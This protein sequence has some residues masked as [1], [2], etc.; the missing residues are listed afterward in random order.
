MNTPDTLPMPRVEPQALDAAAL[1][2]RAMLARLFGPPERRSFAVRLWNGVVEAAAESRFTLVLRQPAALRRMLFPPSELR[3][4]EAFI[5]GDVDVDGDLEEAAVLSDRLTERMRSP[6]RAARVAAGL[7]RLP[8]AHRARSGGDRRYRPRLRTALHTRRGDRAAVRFHY[9]LGN[10]FYRL[11]LDPRMVYSCAYFATGTEDIA[12]AQLAKLDH[13]C[14]K[15]RLKPGERLLDIGCGWGGLVVHAARCYGV[16]ALGITLSEAQAE[17]ARR[18]AAEAGMAD[19][20]RIEVRDYRE[21][22]DA[23]AFDKLVSVGMIEHVGRARLA[24]YF[25]QAFRLLKPGGCFLNHGIVELRPRVPRGPAGWPARLVWRPGRFIGQYI[26]PGGELLGPA[27]TI[28]AGEAAGFE[29]RD[30]ESLREHYAL[31]LRAWRR[32]LEERR[33]EAC[34]MVG[35]PTYRAWRLYL[36]SSAR[37]F[38]VGRLGLLQT[39]FVKTD[40]G[41]CRLPWSRADLYAA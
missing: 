25:A 27:E 11:W 10:D 38:A 15:L 39:L 35:E 14:R 6:V 1:A 13:I 21:L 7:L 28:A 24:T 2:T 33:A 18:A 40:R 16:E 20:C 26:F 37:Q 19:R 17:A 32:R 12:T 41:E 4:A 23:A 9:D 30:V 34:A 3:A 31:T 5:H 22:T 8:P 36:A 29:T